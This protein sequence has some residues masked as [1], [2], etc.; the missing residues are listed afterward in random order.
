MTAPQAERSH[1]WEREANEHYVEARWVWERFFEEE[2]IGGNVW[3]PC[4]GFGR[5]I[6]A[7]RASGLEAYATDLVD[8]G[9][10]YFGVVDFLDA[11]LLGR[12]DNIVMNPP[13]SLGREFV[14]RALP[15]ARGKVAAIFP[16]RRLAA[17]GKWIEGTPLYRTYFLTPR[18]SMPPG[19]V[20]L[21]WDKLGKQPRGGKQDFALL[22]WLVGYRGKSETRWLRRNPRR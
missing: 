1:R 19:D 20:A 2:I 14:L 5:S 13:F 6:E 21:N 16:V 4:A 22:V 18:P 9:F 11:E 12:V 3:D 10:G 7:A 15:L 8:R 17:A